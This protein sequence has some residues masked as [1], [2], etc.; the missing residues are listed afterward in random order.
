LFD[1][2]NLSVG[3][4]RWSITG[5]SI[6]LAKLSQKLNDVLWCGKSVPQ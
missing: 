4:R 2:P 5:V 3:F 1:K 6:S